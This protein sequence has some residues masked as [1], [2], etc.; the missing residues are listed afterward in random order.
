MPVKTHKRLAEAILDAWGH[1]AEK[2]GDE[3]REMGRRHSNTTDD[4]QIFQK[5]IWL[6]NLATSI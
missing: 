5:L 4:S 2:A 3:L 1:C 6:V